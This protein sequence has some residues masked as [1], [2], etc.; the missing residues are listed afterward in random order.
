[1]CAADPACAVEHMAFL[2]QALV[3]ESSTWRPLFRVKRVPRSVVARIAR[4]CNATL[5]ATSEYH[6]YASLKQFKAE[7]RCTRRWYRPS[8]QDGQRCVGIQPSRTLADSDVTVSRLCVA[9]AVPGRDSMQEIVVSFGSRN[10]QAP[11][12]HTAVADSGGQDQW[13]PLGVEFES[14]RSLPSTPEAF[15]ARG[16]MAMA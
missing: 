13:H 11:R 4:H 9:E 16:S 12:C 5:H 8:R 6:G 10:C 15:E 2:G 3:R 7:I 14:P 1:M